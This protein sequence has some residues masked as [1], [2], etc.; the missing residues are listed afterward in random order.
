MKRRKGA[1]KRPMASID[2]VNLRLTHNQASAV[3]L[4]VILGHISTQRSGI[5]GSRICGR[6]QQRYPLVEDYRSTGIADEAGL[7]FPC[8]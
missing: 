1:I 8:V 7:H 6:R 5:R 4:R 2:D 3:C